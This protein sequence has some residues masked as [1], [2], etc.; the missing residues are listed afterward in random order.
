M[1]FHYIAHQSMSG[2]RHA[3]KLERVPPDLGGER[4]FSDLKVLSVLPSSKRMVRDSGRA[5]VAKMLTIE[6]LDSARDALKLRGKWNNTQN[7]L[8]FE[9]LAV[10]AASPQAPEPHSSTLS[11]ANE[12]SHVPA[13]IGFNAELVSVGK[14]CA[15]LM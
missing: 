10:R 4:L 11:P 1:G 9:G 14:I 13:H 2:R 5:S 6:F 3:A 8:L 12:D 15:L 7:H